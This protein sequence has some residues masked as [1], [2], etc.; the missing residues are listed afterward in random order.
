[1][2][3]RLTKPSLSH[4]FELYF[5]QALYDP[6]LSWLSDVETKNESIDHEIQQLWMEI[7]KTSQRSWPAINFDSSF[8]KLQASVL[9]KTLDHPSSSISDP[10]I[11]FWNSTYGDQ[12]KLDFPP[13]LLRVLDKLSR[14][15]KI[16]IQKRRA[17]TSP[18]EH[19][20]SLKSV[21]T[22]PQ[23]KVTSTLNTCSKRVELLQTMVDDACKKK[24]PSCP[25]R[26]RSELTEHQKEVRRA[27]QGR[28][29]DCSGHGPGIRIYTSVD[30]SQGNEDSQDSQDIRDPELILD[31]LR[32]V[33]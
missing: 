16:K 3:W 7:I 17:P 25:K 14:L 6:L 18:T 32:R 26:K 19:E 5:I 21:D 33:A 27:Q 23:Y 1:V 9:E 11:A 29:R 24:P 2:E 15:G 10:T 13:C 8:L 20:S 22:H 31:L 12:T 30:F 4:Q 28:T